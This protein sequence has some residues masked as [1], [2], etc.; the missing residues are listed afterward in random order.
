MQPTRTVITRS[1]SGLWAATVTALDS[2]LYGVVS[3][4]IL[5]VTFGFVLLLER[6]YVYG[7]ALLCFLTL[8]ATLLLAFGFF[9]P[10]RLTATPLH[11]TALGAWCFWLMQDLVF[12]LVH[13]FST[14]R[15]PTHALFSR[16]S[17]TTGEIASLHQH[18]SEDH[19]RDEHAHRFREVFVSLFFATVAIAATLWQV[20]RRAPTRLVS[21]L[22]AIYVVTALF[23]SAV[24][25]FLLVRNPNEML[26]RL[27]LF[28]LLYYVLPHVSGW[29]ASPLEKSSAGEQGIFF[30]QI[31]HVLVPTYSQWLVIGVVVVQITLSLWARHEQNR[32]VPFRHSEEP[33]LPKSS[34][35]IRKQV[36]R[37]ANVVTPSRMQ[38]PMVVASKVIQ[39]PLP[40][41]PAPQPLTPPTI[42][43]PSPVTPPKKTLHV[44]SVL[45]M[46]ALC[47]Q[48]RIEQSRIH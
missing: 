48:Q 33:A 25:P 5:I 38:A 8:L 17:L 35:V 45:C 39:L 41:P 19:R 15:A 14:D 18:V 37:D 43:M 24:T 9:G 1:Q 31:Y 23:R 32:R 21:L 46:C 40:Q 30:L 34:I 47:K 42:T 2:F 20:R 6:Q 16:A 22:A 29:L 13:N 44:Y 3:F 28:V 7:V 26:V 27:N 10:P 4:V 36:Q 11:V 12:G